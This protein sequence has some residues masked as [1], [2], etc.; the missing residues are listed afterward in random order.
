MKTD[1][2]DVF[3]ASL[4]RRYGMLALAWSVLL[5]GSLLWNL[6][7]ERQSVLEMATIAARANIQKDIGFRKWVTLHGGVYVSPT[8]HTPPN[9]Y[10]EVPERDVVTTTGK[11]LTLMNPAYVLRE[12]QTDFPDD[13]GTRSR[14]T[15][16][17]PHN[18]ANAPDEWEA[19]ALKSFEQGRKEY[20]E[21]RQIGERRYVSVM[22]PF[23]VEEGCLKCHGYQGYKVGDVRGGISSSVSLDRFFTHRY[24][25]DKVLWLSYGAIWAIGLAVLGILYRRDLRLAVA[26]QLAQEKLHQQLDELL[27]F[28]KLTVGREL[29]MKELADENT[30]LRDRLAAAPSEETKS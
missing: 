26:R 29:R 4:P 9:P 22:E 3:L 13:Y 5:G 25:H 18:P 8:E 15:S 6:H 21:V 2:L 19:R 28:Q 12:L 24:E 7:Q 27:R 30:A 17:M 14:I 1:H 10:L 23:I 11:M 20:L 16:L